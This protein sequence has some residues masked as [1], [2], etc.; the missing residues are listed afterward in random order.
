MRSMCN[1]NDEFKF[2]KNVNILMYNPNYYLYSVDNI[3]N[4]TTFT[5][6]ETVT[7]DKT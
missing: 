6:T 5:L 4:P 3:N 2:V 1:G 7:S